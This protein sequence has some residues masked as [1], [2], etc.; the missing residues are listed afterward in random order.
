VP[1]EPPLP[2]PSEVE[3]LVMREIQP[4]DSLPSNDDEVV[5]DRRVSWH[6]VWIENKSE[7]WPMPLRDPPSV[8]VV[9]QWLNAV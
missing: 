2:V 4:T 1:R 6:K 8:N 3:I 9:E 5:L 7:G